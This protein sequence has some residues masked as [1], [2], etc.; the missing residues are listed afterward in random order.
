METETTFYHIRLCLKHLLTLL[1]ICIRHLLTKA[2]KCANPWVERLL[3]T[4]GPNVVSHLARVVFLPVPS[5]LFKTLTDQSTHLFRRKIS[6]A[7][8]LIVNQF[9][10]LWLWRSV[11]AWKR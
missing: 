3:E 2:Y 1:P 8:G 5:L 7:N 6:K 10:E 11:R 9:A 4:R